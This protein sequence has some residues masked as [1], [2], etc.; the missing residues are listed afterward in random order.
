MPESR[1]RQSKAGCVLGMFFAETPLVS[2]RGWKRHDSAACHSN[3][4]TEFALQV[5]LSTFLDAGIFLEDHLWRLTWL[6]FRALFAL[7]RGGAAPS[8]LP[9]YYVYSYSIMG[10]PYDKFLY[11]VNP[12]SGM[13]VNHLAQYTVVA[14][15]LKMIRLTRNQDRQQQMSLRTA[16]FLAGL[17]GFVPLINVGYA[18][19]RFLPTS[20][21]PGSKP[22]TGRSDW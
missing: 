8:L 1:R 10:G 4:P 17:A 6:A 3:P 9:S 21:G 13:P 18:I 11:P 20:I 5:R 22:R 7:V 14:S 15:D 16:S 12:I 19:R 2:L